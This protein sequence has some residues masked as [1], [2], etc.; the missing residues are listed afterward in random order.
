MAKGKRDKDE[1]RVIENRRA[2][3]DYAIGE[4]LECGIQLYGG[5]VKSVR[6]GQVS[7]QE[8]YVRAEAE[9]PTLWMYGVNIAEYGPAGPV[10]GSSRQALATRVRKLLAHKREIVKLW[11]ASQVKGFTL[12]P[13]KIYFKNGYAK[14]LVGVGEGRKKGDKR[15][16]IKEREM[17]RDIDRA[18][19]K[20]D[21]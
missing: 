20:R 6:A 21:R 1:D 13:L 11:K 4:T 14:C 15:E 10:G 16:A 5:E 18:M 19:S 2:R 17:R 7:L 9:P 3:F 8:G 12:V